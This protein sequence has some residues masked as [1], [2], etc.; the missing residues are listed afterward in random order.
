MSVES[1]AF[2]TLDRRMLR[3]SAAAI[4]VALAALGSAAPA[5]AQPLKGDAQAAKKKLAVCEGC[6]GIPGYRTAYPVV[7][8]VPLLGGQQEAYLLRA[9][10]AYRSGERSH[11]SMRGIANGL[12]EQE[13]A[14]LAAY[15]AGA[16]K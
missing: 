8:H 16:R 6:H 7:Y 12:S 2:Q 1:R 11:P 10:Q 5:L 4:A 3:R 9:L 13:M 14:D 15:Y